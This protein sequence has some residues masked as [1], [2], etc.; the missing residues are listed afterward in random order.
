LIC[1]FS[2]VLI[3]GRKHN[4]GAGRRRN[5]HERLGCSSVTEFLPSMCKALVQ[6]G[7]CKEE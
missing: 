3:V 7:H 5:G 6:S 4:W 2:R 1:F